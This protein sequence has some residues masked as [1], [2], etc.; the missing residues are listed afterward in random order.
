MRRKGAT[1]HAQPPQCQVGA[2]ANIGVCEGEDGHERCSWIEKYSFN[3]H[4]RS[5]EEG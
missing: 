4:G 3:Q 2:K 1:P 5:Y